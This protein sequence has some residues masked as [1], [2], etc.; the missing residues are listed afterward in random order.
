MNEFGLFGFAMT[1]DTQDLYI[2]DAGNLGVVS[3]P[4]CMSDNIE[5]SCKLWL[6]EYDYDQ[7]IGVA[8]LTMLGN[9]HADS[10]L[11][12]AQYTNAILNPNKYL[13]QSQY[14]EFGINSIQS[15]VFDLDSESRQ[16][17]MNATVL[18]NNNTTLEVSVD[19]GS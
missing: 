13:T 1:N 18:L 16:L 2:D 3:G 8:Y 6:T 9:P 15:L 19:V 14:N 11:L 12:N 7:S 4:D 5:T 10:A 17:Q